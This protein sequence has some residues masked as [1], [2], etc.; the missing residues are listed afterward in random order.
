MS[1]VVG[2]EVCSQGAVYKV[3]CRCVLR[4]G[5]VS[6]LRTKSTSFVERWSYY[7]VQVSKNRRRFSGMYLLLWRSRL[8]RKRPPTIRTPYPC[9][10]DTTVG[11]PK[12]GGESEEGNY[13]HNP[14][15]PTLTLRGFPLGSRVP[16][17]NCP[18]V[19]RK[20]RKMKSQ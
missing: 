18:K 6:S 1:P 13:V 17:E 12:K 4:E 14:P 19:E 9:Y 2:R 16:L 8:F 7:G 3:H 10:Q 20:D 5:V 11:T 15:L